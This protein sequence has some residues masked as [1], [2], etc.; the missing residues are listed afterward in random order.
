MRKIILLSALAM[1][2]AGGAIAWAAGGGT[3]TEPMT[4]AVIEHDANLHDTMFPN[5]VGITAGPSTDPV[6]DTL[7]W[8]NVDYNY[9]ADTMQVGHDQ[10]S[11]IRTVTP[12][13]E[14][15]VAVGSPDSKGAWEC[16]WT[17]WIGLGHDDSITVE[18]PFFDTANST[19]AI[20]GG[21]GKFANARGSMHLVA[22]PPNP[23]YGNFARYDFIFNVLP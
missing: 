13:Q 17:T 15:P 21:T 14:L 16:N 10:G 18:G 5:L 7:T 23:K 2:L 22:L 20:I 9:P 8:S 12:S 11:C 1:A 3:V 19:L 6:G 4:V